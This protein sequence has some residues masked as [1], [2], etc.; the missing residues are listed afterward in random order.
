MWCAHDRFLQT[1]TAE[2]SSQAFALYLTAEQ[3]SPGGALLPPPW[4]SYN[5]RPAPHQVPYKREMGF[6]A[7]YLS[8][9]THNL[10][11]S[12]KKPSCSHTHKLE[13]QTACATYPSTSPQ[14]IQTLLWY[15]QQLPDKVKNTACHSCAEHVT[16]IQKQNLKS[17]PPCTTALQLTAKQAHASEE[18]E[19]WSW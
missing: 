18:L 8:L 9:F 12:R 2:G 3:H 1:S 16:A 15:F 13:S 5:S 19:N 6:A 17:I 10:W 7:L 14:E 11:E 4:I